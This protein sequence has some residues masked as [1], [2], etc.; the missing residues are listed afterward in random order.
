[1]QIIARGGQKRASWHALVTAR[2]VDPCVKGGRIG[3]YLY[4]VG[5]HLAAGQRIVDAVGSLAL[6]IAH[7]GAKVACATGTSRTGSFHDIRH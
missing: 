4:E 7:V 3:L 1:M 2:D 6:A 5:E